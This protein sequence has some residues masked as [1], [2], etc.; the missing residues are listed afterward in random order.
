MPKLFVIMPFGL[1]RHEGVE[2]DFDTVYR[3]VI[4]PT[5]EGVGW[6]TLRIDEVST[7]G[8]INDQY[9]RE[10]LNAE[11]VLADIS[12]PNANVY[13][14][15]GVRHSVSSSGTLLISSAT[16]EDVPFDLRGQRIIFFDRSQADMLAQGISIALREFTNSTGDQPITSVLGA[17]RRPR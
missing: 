15:L 4:R 16:P 2:F 10:L 11:L 1:K 12:I 3:T 8:P 7:P 9:L 13:Y 6:E 5:A 17:R 14:E